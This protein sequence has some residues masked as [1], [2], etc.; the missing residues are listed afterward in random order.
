[1]NIYDKRHAY[2]ND[3]IYP[4]TGAYERGLLSFLKRASNGNQ[5]IEFGVG[6]GRVAFPLAEQGY[7]VIG[8]DRSCDMLSELKVRDIRSAVTPLYGDF[9]VPLK[10]GVQADVVLIVCNTIFEAEDYEAQRTIFTNAYNHLN[11]GGLFVVETVNPLPLLRRD[12]S[13]T[14]IRLLTSDACLLENTCTDPFSQRLVTSFLVFEG[15]K[16]PC[17]FKQTIRLVTPLEM[18][19]VA[20]SSGMILASRMGWWDGSPASANTD[21]IISIY[22]RG[23]F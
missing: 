2:L 19:A 4:I 16:P 15:A 10:L 1:M 23:D 13:V 18:D 3:L 5:I 9:T 17:H 20:T 12:G 22:E 8:V 21:L 14:S 6:T 11:D 7:Q